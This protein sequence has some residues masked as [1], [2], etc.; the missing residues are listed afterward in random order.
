VVEMVDLG[1]AAARLGLRCRVYMSPEL[2]RETGA[3]AL[4]KLRDALHATH[5]DPA[6]RHFRTV[7]LA[8][9]HAEIDRTSR[10][11]LLAEARQFLARARA[12]IGGVSEGGSMLA[13]PVP[14]PGGIET[15]IF[16][17]WPL[18]AAVRAPV[19]GVVSAVLWNRD[20]MIILTTPGGIQRVFQFSLDR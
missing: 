9:R 19:A 2:A 7:V 16:H 12:G 8:G 13:L 3:A 10:L 15:V 11:D 14:A 5:D 4:E 1:K 6:T 20:P 17:V 18:N